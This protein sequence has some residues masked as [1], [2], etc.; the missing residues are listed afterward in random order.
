ME[1][2]TRVLEVKGMYLQ[3]QEALMNVSDHPKTNEKSWTQ[4][5]S[6]NGKKSFEHSNSPCHSRKNISPWLQLIDFRLVI[7]THHF[8]NVEKGAE[9]AN[10]PNCDKN[11]FID[12]MKFEKLILLKT[13]AFE[14]FHW[15]L[16]DQTGMKVIAKN[17]EVDNQGPSKE[18]GPFG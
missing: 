4:E 3:L 18:W 7:R 11:D 6:N 15:E 16:L 1:L 2:K 17:V 10:V 8:A 13:R 5:K 14:P 12:T 9:V